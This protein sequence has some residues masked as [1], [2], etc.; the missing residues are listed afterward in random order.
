MGAVAT[1]RITAHP[2]VSKLASEAQ[3]VS[4]IHSLSSGGSTFRKLLRAQGVAIRVAGSLRPG[5]HTPHACRS[6][7]EIKYT[8]VCKSLQGWLAPRARICEKNFAIPN[9][10][11]TQLF[12]NDLRVNEKVKGGP[13]LAH[14][15][16]VLSAECRLCSD[17]YYQYGDSGGPPTQPKRQQARRARRT[18]L[19]LRMESAGVRRGVAFP[20]SGRGQYPAQTGTVGVRVVPA[21]PR[22]ICAEGASG[23][24]RWPLQSG[25]FTTIQ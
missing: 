6:R 10:H 11:V 13:G 22:E 2:P 15:L 5:L 25:S 21:V 1:V 3:Q 7:S 18:G 12:I 23:K 16:R 17:G 19:L 9:A 14:R 4:F 24:T 20:E 8:S